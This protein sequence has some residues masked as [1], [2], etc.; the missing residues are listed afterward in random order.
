MYITI[1]GTPETMSQDE[2]ERLMMEIVKT[3]N[4]VSRMGYKE[5]EVMVWFPADRMAKGLG[6]EFSIEVVCLDA[7]L[8]AGPINRV[9]DVAYQFC[10]AVARFFPDFWRIEC[11]V[12]SFGSPI[13]S[14]IVRSHSA[15]R[16]I[17]TQSRTT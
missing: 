2:L 1:Y 4:K 5:N 6:H 16:A 7:D 12:H 17:L 15:G 14:H 10:S 13:P 8:Q 3:T 11:Y 9:D